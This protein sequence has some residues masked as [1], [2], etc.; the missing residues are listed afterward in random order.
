MCLSDRFN[1]AYDYLPFHCK[2]HILNHGGHSRSMSKPIQ[3][4][5]QSVCLD[6]MILLYPAEDAANLNI[7]DAIWALFVSRPVVI[8]LFCLCCPVWKR[9]RQL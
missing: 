2:Y 7:R 3:K 9:E 6:C 8:D 5:S 4:H 1:C